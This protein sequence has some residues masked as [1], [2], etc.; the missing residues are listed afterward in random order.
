M[1]N[2]LMERLAK[3]EYNEKKIHVGVWIPLSLDI[4]LKAASKKLGLRK[5]DFVR[6]LLR[7]VLLTEESPKPNYTLTR[8]APF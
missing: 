2:E 8:K 6:G 1:M 3:P 5:T 7:E 4:P